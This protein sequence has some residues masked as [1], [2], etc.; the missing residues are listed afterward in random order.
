MS[1][2]TTGVNDFSGTHAV[3]PDLPVGGTTGVN[4]AASYGVADMAAVHA[5]MLANGVH[6]VDLLLDSNM[7]IL[8]TGNG[9][10][11]NG[12]GGYLMT[13][14]RDFPLQKLVQ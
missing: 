8:R 13:F 12:S 3:H 5:S 11:A 9:S 14:W 7:A 6:S 2:Y 4:V 1:T 10:G